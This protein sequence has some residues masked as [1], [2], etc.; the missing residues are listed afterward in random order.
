MQHIFRPG[1][2][3]RAAGAIC[4]SDEKILL[5]HAAPCG[6]FGQSGQSSVVKEPRTNGHISR[7]TAHEARARLTHAR[8]R[9]FSESLVF[10]R[11]T[12]QKNLREIQFFV[13]PFA[14]LTHELRNV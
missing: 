1:F 3:T 6:A 8:A 5:R 12:T 4:E 9:N 11:K 7:S 2:T 13:S 14:R 10:Q